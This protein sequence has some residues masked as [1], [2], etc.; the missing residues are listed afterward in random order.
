MRAQ[1]PDL[2]T[3][4]SRKSSFSNESGGNCVEV[5]DGFVNAVPVRDSKDP[6]GPTFAVHLGRLL[7]VCRCCSPGRVPPAMTHV[8]PTRPA[9]SHRAGRAFPP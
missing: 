6:H 8:T 9:L 3:A 4:I 1:R 5:A 2:T 7:L